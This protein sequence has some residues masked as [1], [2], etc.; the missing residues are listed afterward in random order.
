MRRN[1]ERSSGWPRVWMA[2]GLAAATAVAHPLS[3]AAPRVL[4][5]GT[6]PE[7]RRLEELKDFDGYFPFEPSP[8]PEAWAARAEQV[9]RQMLVA[10]GFV[11]H[12]R[13]RRPPRRSCTG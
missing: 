9:R 13:R 10:T 12:A 2:I 11:A 7:D 5:D 8:T 4:P 6:L 3:A 1:D